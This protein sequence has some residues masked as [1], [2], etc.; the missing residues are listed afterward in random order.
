MPPFTLDNPGQPISQWAKDFHLPSPC[1]ICLHSPGTIAASCLV[2]YTEC[3][4]TDRKH[5]LRPG[6]APL[7]SP[8]VAPPHS[9]ESRVLPRPRGS[10]QH[11]PVPIS[12]IP[13]PAR[14]RLLYP[15]PQSLRTPPFQCYA[16]VSSFSRV[17]AGPCLCRCPASGWIAIVIQIWGECP[18]AWAPV[19]G[20][21]HGSRLVTSSS[22]EWHPAR[23]RPGRRR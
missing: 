16:S 5:R 20:A 14:L 19:L 23:H 1:R 10:P 22:Q 9:G 13:L 12:L 11:L 3:A 7:P 21:T 6:A 2:R 17:S 8:P 4:P 18:S 15:N